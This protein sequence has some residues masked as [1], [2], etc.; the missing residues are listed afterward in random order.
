M[1]TRQCEVVAYTR[2]LENLTLLMEACNGSVDLIERVFIELRSPDKVAKFHERCN[3]PN[4][5][6]RGMTHDCWEIHLRNQN[7]C[8]RQKG[9]KQTFIKALESSPVHCLKPRPSGKRRRPG[10]KG[11][12]AILTPRPL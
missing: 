11:A 5:L 9:E 7:S 1:L 6:R 12:A 2:F 3:R 8:L 10:N 4:H